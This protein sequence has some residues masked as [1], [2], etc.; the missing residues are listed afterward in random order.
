MQVM[1]GKGNRSMAFTVAGIVGVF[2]VL[3]WLTQK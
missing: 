2:I 1:N 3:W